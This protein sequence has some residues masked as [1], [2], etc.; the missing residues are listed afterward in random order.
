MRAFEYE[1]TLKSKPSAFKGSKRCEGYALVLSTD[2]STVGLYPFGLH[3]KKK[4]ATDVQAPWDVHIVG[5]VI[6]VSSR[7]CTG[8]AVKGG[9]ACAR[10]F[11]LSSNSTLRGILDRMENGIKPGTTLQWYGIDGLHEKIHEKDGK[12]TFH[13]LESLNHAKTLLRKA[14]ALSDHKRFVMAVSSDNIQRLDRIISIGLRQKKGIK[15]LLDMVYKAEQGLYKARSFTEREARHAVLLWRLGGN[16][17]ADINHRATGAPGVTYLRKHSKVPPLLASP[18]QPTIE[19]VQQNATATIDSLLE[20]LQERFGET[21]MR[22]AVLMY[23]ELKT[24][25][26]IRYDLLSN[27][28]LGVCREHAHQVSLKFVNEGDMVELFRAIDDG[29]VHC[30]GEV[31]VSCYHIATSKLI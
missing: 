4:H 28:F 22:H 27:H 1:H 13:R 16:R 20:V 6:T 24:E 25:S 31:R 17:V 30:A 14:A 3:R 10:C 26:R 5:E 9:T 23:D 18:G 2:K 29:R 8:F 19:E 15:S 12:L 7:N 11:Q 21:P